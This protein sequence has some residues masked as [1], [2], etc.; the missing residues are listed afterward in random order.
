MW[1]R[2]KVTFLGGNTVLASGVAE[3]FNNQS[4]RKVRFIETE[5]M[6]RS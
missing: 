3:P 1:K 5:E 2:Y 4:G 6:M